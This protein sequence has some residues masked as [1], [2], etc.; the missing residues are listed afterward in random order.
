M[1]LKGF[2]QQRQMLG[3]DNEDDRSG[4]GHWG[5]TAFM[6]VRTSRLNLEESRSNFPSALPPW[7]HTRLVTELLKKR[8]L[9]RKKLTSQRRNAS[10]QSEKCQLLRRRTEHTFCAVFFF[11]ITATCACLFL[12]GLQSSCARKRS[13]RPEGEG[14][15][16]RKFEGRFSGRSLLS[17]TGFVFNIC[18]IWQ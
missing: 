8:F 16:H 14:K 13:G 1:S 3:M 2:S 12:V 15:G 10:T 5:S 9:K 7:S 18:H 6:T 11:F 17:V 4:T